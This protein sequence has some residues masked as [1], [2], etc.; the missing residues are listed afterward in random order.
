MG[1]V[2]AAIS[3]L[4]MMLVLLHGPAT[5]HLV[6]R[7]KVPGVSGAATAPPGGPGGGGTPAEGGGEDEGGA[8]SNSLLSVEGHGAAYGNNEVIPFRA[9][10]SEP[11]QVT[12]SPTL[13]IRVGGTDREAVFDTLTDGDTVLIFNYTVIP[14]E[15]D[16]DGV[17]IR[18]NALAGADI[19]AVD[20]GTEMTLTNAS[21]LTGAI[22]NPT[23]AAPVVNYVQAGWSWDSPL[24]TGRQENIS[25]QF[26]DDMSFQEN[27]GSVV[28]QLRVGTQLVETQACVNYHGAPTIE[29]YCIYTVAAGH[30][31]DDGIEVLAVVLKN[32]ATLNA[33]SDNLPLETTIPASAQNEGYRVD[34]RPDISGVSVV[35]PT[36]PANLA[37][38]ESFVIAVTYPVTI[39][40]TGT[41]RLAVQIGS[42]T[43]YAD[44][45]P[46]GSGTTT[47]QFSYTVQPGD[48]DQDGIQIRNDAID[49]NGGTL[50]HDGAEVRLA[51]ASGV[52]G[53][54]S[55]LRV[56]A[57]GLGPI[58][59]YVQAGWSWDSPLVTGRQENISIQFNED[60]N[61]Q[62]NGGSVVLQLRVGTQLVETQACVNYHGAPTIELYC[63]YTV[64][65]GHYDDDGIEV[66][67]V[68]LKNG[69]TLN[70][71]SDNLP[72]ET[73]IPAS[74]QNEGYRV[75]GRLGV[76]N[77][78]IPDSAGGSY[79]TGQPMVFTL[80]FTEAVNLVGGTPTLSVQ[81]GAT[82]RQAAFTGGSGSTALTF[83]YIPIAED[84]DFD[85]VQ[86]HGD[87]I[88]LSGGATLSTVNG[89]PVRPASTTGANF[90]FPYAKV[91]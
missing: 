55:R 81:V 37:V 84:Y 91:N 11:V 71:A 32:G 75:D 33:A 51:L 9:T 36:E 58:V 35:S 18:E 89:D 26:N 8:D 88:V 80:S 30:Y 13:G 79:V 82:M 73:T 53:M 45:V 29:L 67:A 61:Y 56:G 12:G 83:T 7:Y 63:I 72:L 50:T 77:V 34:G 41:P 6:L 15:S 78:E 21:L 66:L 27:G 24:V 23:E 20:D 90:N 52:S 3:G 22:V 68:V 59:N 49:L 14:G 16:Q 31:D 64:A 62:E 43:R 38:G 47:L 2:L 4:A 86:V 74:A 87:F 76:D 46:G 42:T 28:L 1:K 85:G 19:T 5:A 65:A 10:F 39:D 48:V 70:A 17:E 54:M 69:A 25:I 57:D 40:V 44:F 60:V